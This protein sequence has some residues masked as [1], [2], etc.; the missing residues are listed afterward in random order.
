MKKI[1]FIILI[2]ALHSCGK[3]DSVSDKKL[4]F[5][6]DFDETIY[7]PID[8]QFYSNLI[9]MQS[10]LSKGYSKSEYFDFIKHESRGVNTPNGMIKLAE[11][12]KN[13]FGISVKKQDVLYTVEML[14]K[15][16]TKE[17]GDVIKNL[18]S[19]GHQVLIIGGGVW[20]CAVIP[21]F[22]NQFGVKKSDIYS[23]YFKD[24]S[25]KNIDKIFSEDFRYANCENPDKKTPFSDKKSE[26]IKMLKK[27]G[28]IKGKVV[29]IGD[30]ENDLEV[31]ISGEAYKFIG[32]GVNRYRKNV[33]LESKIYVKTIDE[34]KK[35]IN[36]I[37]A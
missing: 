22:L 24:F 31:W 7:N 35:Q 28:K 25:E 32:F 21:D 14:N 29:H 33:E 30:G 23:G 26:L 27:E 4:T 3:K 18:K 15:L 20:G 37:I 12:V 36:L 13:K 11:S 1:L 5:I 8:L 17:I 9:Y 2:I 16:Q 34:F 19:Q 6:F 10:V